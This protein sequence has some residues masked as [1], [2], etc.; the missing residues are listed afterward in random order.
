MTT[1]S[2]HELRLGHIEIPV[3]DPLAARAWYQDVLG[4]EHLETQG[5]RFVWMR[6][7]PLGVMLRPG[8]AERARVPA[9]TM[10]DPEKDPVINFVFYTATLEADAE[11]LRERGVELSEHRACFHFEDA[12]GN[13]FQLVDPGDD[14]SG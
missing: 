1:E 11:R 9:E 6:L 5:D 13:R 10:G 8:A 3:S 14:H 4:F 2:G 12:D 7:G